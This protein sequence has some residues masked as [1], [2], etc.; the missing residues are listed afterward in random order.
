MAL[1]LLYHRRFESTKLLGNSCS[2]TLGPGVE[3]LK[4]SLCQACVTVPWDA[5]MSQPRASNGG[6][7]TSPEG[8][9]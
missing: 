9:N 8:E 6:Q 1:L 3:R 5:Q 4:K 2:Q 7:G